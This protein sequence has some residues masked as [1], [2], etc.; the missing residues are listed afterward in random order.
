MKK[1]SNKPKE[2]IKAF[3]ITSFG[4][5]VFNYF[6][7]L[8]ILA[9]LLLVNL[10][11]SLCGYILFEAINV[12]IYNYKIKRKYS[13]DYK[14]DKF[15]EDSKKLDEI[16][17]KKEFEL[18]FGNDVK[19]LNLKFNIPNNEVLY[20]SFV[21]KNCKRCGYFDNDLKYIECGNCATNNLN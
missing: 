4:L 12:L 18:L 9:E 1:I 21:N 7:N 13:L 2:W 14:S 16:R 15:K 5:V 11:S 3:L 6:A 8:E 17:K 20:S 19:D 10:V